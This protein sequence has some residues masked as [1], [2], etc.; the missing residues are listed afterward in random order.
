MYI[1][2]SNSLDIKIQLFFFLMNKNLG[3][4][5]FED[6]E[7]TYHTILCSFMYK[8]L[9]WVRVYIESISLSLLDFIDWMGYK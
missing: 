4:L 9:E 1:M 6:F 7:L 3:I 5:A 2:L 8:F